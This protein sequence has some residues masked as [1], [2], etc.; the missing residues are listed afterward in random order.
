MNDDSMIYIDNRVNSFKC[1]VAQDG[2]KYTWSDVIDFAYT[3]DL[4]EAGFYYSPIK[5]TPN[6][7]TC[8]YCQKSITVEKDSSIEEITSDHAKRSISCPIA[9]LCHTYYTCRGLLDDEIKRCWTKSKFRDPFNQLSV[10]LRARFFKDFP[11][12]DTDFRPNSKTLADAGFIYSPR[13]AGDD[14][15]V[16]PYCRCA[17]DSWDEQDDPID[18]HLSNTSTYCYFLDKYV[19]RKQGGKKRD[20][21]SPFDESIDLDDYDNDDRGRDE[22]GQ[23]QSKLNTQ[24]ETKEGD[25]SKRIT[26]SQ[27]AHAHIKEDPNLKY[28]KKLP[29]EDLLQEFIQVSKHANGDA[30]VTK[31]MDSNTGNQ[32]GETKEVIRDENESG[33]TEGDNLPNHKSGKEDEDNIDDDNDAHMDDIDDIE[34]DEPNQSDSIEQSSDEDSQVE[35]VSIE[36]SSNDEYDPTSDSFEPTNDSESIAETKPNSEKKTV[37][38]ADKIEKKLKVQPVEH[39]RPAGDS[40]SPTRRKKMIKR[41]TPA[42]AFEDSSTDQDYNE[43]HIVKLEKNIK[44][45]TILPA[46]EKSFE[47]VEVFVPPVRMSPTKLSPSPKKTSPI[48]RSIFD[49]SDITNDDM[50][51]DLKKSSTKGDFVNEGSGDLE[52]DENNDGAM[53][54][55][56]GNVADGIHVG[57]ESHI[58]HVLAADEPRT[59]YLAKE[60]I[61]GCSTA[62]NSLLDSKHEEDEVKVL[63]KEETIEVE[64]QA[65]IEVPEASPQKETS[66]LKDATLQQSDAFNNHPAREL[67]A[68]AQESVADCQSQASVS[69]PVALENS[70]SESDYSDYLNEINE[71]DK[72]FDI[73]DNVEEKYVAGDAEPSASEGMPEV[74]NVNFEESVGGE[75]ESAPS[76]VDHRAETN[77]EPAEIVKKINHD[78]KASTSV[79]KEV[80]KNDHVTNMSSQPLKRDSRSPAN[81]TQL[82]PPKLD[83]ISVDTQSPPKEAIAPALNEAKLNPITHNSNSYIE[84]NSKVNQS[85]AEEPDF[86]DMTGPLAMDSFLNEETGS[87]AEEIKPI[88]ESGCEAKSMQRFVQQMENLDNSSKELTTLA[89]SKYELHNDLDGDLTRFIAE[90]PEDEEKMTI[91]QWIEHCATNC[92]DIVAQSIR[93]MNQY[94]LDEYDRAIMTLEAMEES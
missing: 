51:G 75:P 58:D 42:P 76:S 68:V 60:P 59:S 47:Q 65:E 73:D 48:K 54:P 22:I 25:D 31:S 7:I 87:T 28:W 63:K 45:S 39:K 43:A 66:S 82:S 86:S 32:E 19:E 61:Q 4:V 24:Q 2:K 55:N 85:E 80:V 15:V 92:K 50:G 13:Y 77:E 14:R 34:V 41:T 37:T 6:R 20:E 5:R 94:I 62:N 12:D 18:E 11:L 9:S 81:A 79:E 78:T 57:V 36:S 10:K 44:S 3:N 89:D 69:R 83:H 91:E 90:I 30:G 64:K 35:D 88:P 23:Y 16:C 71:V 52:V 67:K 74:V 1:P 56:D 38:K 49:L 26:R 17:L 29:D 8:A 53:N 46:E 93:E 21:K 33:A 70:D 72:H 40:L 27:L 84:S